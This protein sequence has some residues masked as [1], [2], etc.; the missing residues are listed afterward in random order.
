MLSGE[1]EVRTGTQRSNYDTEATF[2]LEGIC[3]F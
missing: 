3:Q 1:T 2:A